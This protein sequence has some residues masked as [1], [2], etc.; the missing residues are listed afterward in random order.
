MLWNFPCIRCVDKD[1][2]QDDGKK[3]GVKGQNSKKGF[4]TN[5]IPAL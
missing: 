3:D 5:S 2:A 4:K 1:V